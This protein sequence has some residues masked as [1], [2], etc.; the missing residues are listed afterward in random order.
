MYYRKQTF[1]GAEKESIFF[2]GGAANREKHIA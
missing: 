2:L 1:I